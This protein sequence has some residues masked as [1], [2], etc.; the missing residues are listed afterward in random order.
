MRKFAEVKGVKIFTV[1]TPQSGGMAEMD[2]EQIVANFPK[3]K[4]LPASKHEPPVVISHDEAQGLLK[5]DGLPAAGWPDRVWRTG[6]DLFADFKDVPR[7]VA[8]LIN[9]KAFKKCSVEIY[10]NYT[11]GAGTQHGKALRRIALLGGAIPRIRGLSDWAALYG[12]DAAG[13]I[14]SFAE[15]DQPY[16]TYSA[17][18]TL[19]AAVEKENVVAK[20]SRIWW[21]W[22]DQR[23]EI[24]ASAALTS[25]EKKAKLQAMSEELL[26][27]LEETTG[28]LV[29]QYQE[30]GSKMEKKPDPGVK[31]YTEAEV[32]ARIAEET[33]AYTERLAKVEAEQRQ[34]SVAAFAERL[35]KAGLAPAVA[36]DPQFRAFAEQLESDTIQSFAEGK[37]APRGWFETFMESLIEKAQS[38]KLVVAFG[39]R[40]GE[41]T[42]AGPAP[43]EDGETALYNKAKKYAE[44]HKVPFAD[45]VIIVSEAA[46]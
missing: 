12:E 39:E 43:G 10:D 29:D 5:A 23:W 8:D 11:D 4:E 45:A 22:D 20:L 1:G 37:T 32:A 26:T 40:T 44:D 27:L 36:D 31:T 33:K 28:E 6:K 30:G 19:T 15:G 16:Q 35:K 2:L 3:L 9:N 18:E 21:T 42:A 25:E 17:D 41:T 34:S 24:M 46:G 13:R 7:V 38:G 14:V